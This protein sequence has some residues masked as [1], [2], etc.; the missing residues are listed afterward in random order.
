MYSKAFSW[1]EYLKENNIKAVPFYFFSKVIIWIFNKKFYKG[2][3]PFR[4]KKVK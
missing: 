2:T 4:N 3:F 1:E